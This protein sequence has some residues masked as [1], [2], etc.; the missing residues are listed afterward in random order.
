MT[1]TPTGPVNHDGESSQAETASV[2]KSG[3]A[4]VHRLSVGTNSAVSDVAVERGAVEA[5][6]TVDVVA[7][8]TPPV[9]VPAVVE[10]VEERMPQA[11]RGADAI[12]SAVAKVDALVQSVE[13]R[14]AQIEEAHRK[15]EEMLAEVHQIAEALTFSDALRERINA[16]VART[17]RLRGENDR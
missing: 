4:P 6:T 17:Q 14:Q 9:V 15:A 5:R 2:F 12:E 13:A 7:H 11:S 1:S 10:E 8:P 3:E 16:T